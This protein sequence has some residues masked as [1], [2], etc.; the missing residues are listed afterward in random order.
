MT[1]N[2]IAFQKALETVAPVVGNGGNASLNEHYFFKDDAI[3]GTD[4]DRYIS[5]KF[6]TGITCAVNSK[7]LLPFVKSLTSENVHISLEN[8]V[9][10][11]GF[12]KVSA[13]FATVEFEAPWP[14][15]E[16]AEFVAFPFDK[17]RFNACY[18][19][20]A[21]FVSVDETRR[22]LMGVNIVNTEQGV[23]MQAT[24]G[25]RLARVKLNEPIEGLEE[26]L[27]MPSFLALM[28][29]E[30]ITE[31]AVAPSC[32]AF[33]CKSG[34]IYAGR[35]LIGAYP[36]T[37]QVIPNTDSPDYSKVAFPETVVEHVR[38][39]MIINADSIKMVITEDSCTITCQAD[40]NDF[41]ETIPVSASKEVTVI[42]NPKYL[43]PLLKA[44]TTMF[45]S[46]NSP[47]S[48][49]YM[50]GKLIV[51]PLRLS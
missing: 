34:N 51:M 12:G 1:V 45:I 33:T 42:Y 44:S 4:F 16:K 32:V 25:R 46:A 11:V 6:T 50:D 10:T 3:V 9:L 27:L 8:A 40:D 14:D 19:V 22:I 18:A 5:A 2:R 21:P 37:V 29:N 24:D 35:R 39:A 49:S 20:T 31:Y 28:R 30:E 41:V 43:L 38:R 7:K 13:K 15:M 36:N 23:F 48:V 47:G 17:E 26:L